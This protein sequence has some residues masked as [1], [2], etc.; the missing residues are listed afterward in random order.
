MGSHGKQMIGW[1]EISQIQLAPD[2]IAQQWFSDGAVR[3]VAQGARIIGSPASPIY[4]DMKYD[5]TTPLGLNWAGNVSVETSYT[6]DPA[7]DVPGVGE[8]DLLGVEAALWTE[9][10][11]TFDDLAVMVFPRLLSL[12][13]IGWTP[14]DQRNWGEYRERLAAHGPRLTALGVEFYQ[15]SEV[16]WK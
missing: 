7:T 2:T 6:W 9:T 11:R 3:A 8:A 15:S 14:Q 12:A 4:L 10:L 13:E 1:E 16:E 5:N